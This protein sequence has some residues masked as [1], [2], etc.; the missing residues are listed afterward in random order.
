MRRFAQKN[1]ES[2]DGGFIDEK[3]GQEGIKKIQEDEALKKFIE[4]EKNMIEYCQQLKNFGTGLRAG[5]VG[6]NVSDPLSITAKVAFLKL[7][8]KLIEIGNDAPAAIK[9]KNDI[10][11]QT[12][13][14]GGLTTIYQPTD[15]VL[16][17]PSAKR[18]I[19]FVGDLINFAYTLTLKPEDFINPIKILLT[20][21]ACDK[22]HPDI[23]K[24]LSIGL[25]GLPTPNYLDHPELED[26][27]REK[28]ASVSSLATNLAS[29][30]QNVEAALSL[31]GLLTGN[32]LFTA[33]VR[34][35]GGIVE[36]ILTAISIIASPNTYDLGAYAG[37]DFK[38][39]GIDPSSPYAFL[40]KIPGLSQY[41]KSYESKPI[42]EEAKKASEKIVENFK[43]LSIGTYKIENG[44]YVP[45]EDDEAIKIVNMQDPRGDT[46]IMTVGDEWPKWG[47]KITGIFP[48]SNP[49]RVEYKDKSGNYYILN[50]LR[51]ASKEPI[52]AFTDKNIF[53]QVMK[54]AANLSTSGVKGDVDKLLSKKAS[55]IISLMY[56]LKNKYPWIGNSKNAKWTNLQADILSHLI[57][58]PKKRKTKP[59]PA[60]GSVATTPQPT[61]VPNLR[62]ITLEN[63]KQ[64][65]FREDQSQLIPERRGS[66]VKVKLFAAIDA[67]KSGTLSQM[68][69]DKWSDIGKQAIIEEAIDRLQRAGFNVLGPTFDYRM[70]RVPPI[71]KDI[72]N[73]LSPK[74]K[75]L[76]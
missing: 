73:Q 3:I 69:W 45:S 59:E 28:M 37:E 11:F 42:A 17:S 61:A 46:L 72:L 50:V 57:R 23:N 5:I 15:K 63:Y 51:N 22:S 58:S 26:Q 54:D 64:K 8:D 30:I 40:N 31:M 32:V 44:Q 34:I 67:I 13:V 62:E 60:P 36:G 12:G 20:P 41:I 7:S 16:K 68:N 38:G 25:P 21:Y 33:A 48:T 55:D 71:S 14:L 76:R 56:Q 1:G 70:P 35:A 19:P 29:L 65:Y 6:I 75:S 43:L 4:S 39:G 27:Q 49:A 47:I 52:S 74:Y 10:V 24:P 66:A 9:A 2:T 18:F 53:D